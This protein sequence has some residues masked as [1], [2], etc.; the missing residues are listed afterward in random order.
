M[1]LDEHADFP[2][3]PR[4]VPAAELAKFAE[5]SQPAVRKLIEEKFGAEGIDMLEAMQAAIAEASM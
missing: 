5:S 3:R 2:G 4:D 1:L